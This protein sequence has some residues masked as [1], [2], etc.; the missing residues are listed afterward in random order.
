MLNNNIGPQVA[1]IDDIQDEVLSIEK[2][3]EENQIGYKYFNVDYTQPKYPSE[4]IQSLEIVFLDLYYNTNFSAGFEPYQCIEWLIHVV[5]KWKKYI[6]VI[7]SKD[8]HETDELLRLMKEM[9]APIPMVIER[10]LKSEYQTGTYEYNINNL[11]QKLNNKLQKELVQSSHTFFGQ[12]LKIN[13]K[14]VLINC[15][16]DNELKSFE[17]RTF[18]IDILT[19]YI[20]IEIGNFIE[21]NVTSTLGQLT[22][23]FRNIYSDMSDIFI[24]SD[25]FEDI[26]DV[27]FL[28]GE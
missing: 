24:K 8:I 2:H 6:L 25:D 20:E 4:P 22:Y 23:N 3:L 14:T 21:I 15:L 13:E 7:W 9:D 26:G 12:I 5:P 16:I 27:S 10:S 11:I 1:I 28:N 17:L 18:D 19:N